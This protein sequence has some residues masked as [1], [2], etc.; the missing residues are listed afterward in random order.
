VPAGS[1]PRGDCPDDT[2][3]T[4]RH[5]GTCDGQGAC[6]LYV[7]GTACGPSSCASS[8]TEMVPPACD[9]A[10]TCVGASP[11]TRDCSPFICASNACLT[12]CQSSTDCVVPSLCFSHRCR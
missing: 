9:G 7:S 10:G 8:M 4:C 1:D 6:R 11:A 3:A 2:A 5:D 12:S